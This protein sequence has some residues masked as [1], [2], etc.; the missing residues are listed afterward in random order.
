M[1][2]KQLP[3]PAAAPAAAPADAV[4]EAR[5]VQTALRPSVSAARAIKALGTC[6]SA[7]L[8][9]LAAELSE[10]CRMVSA[11][12]MDRPEAILVAQAATLD[13]AFT[14][15]LSRAAANFG[16]HLDAAQLYMRLALRAQAQ[17]ARTLET[18]GQL[19]NPPASA[20]FIKQANVGNAVQV[21]NGGDP[22]R[23]RESD[24]GR[25]ELLEHTDGDRL[26]TRAAGT[27]SCADPRLEAVETRHRPK[28][29]GR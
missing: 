21:N 5:R 7:D 1:S 17:C 2:R 22:A 20:T 6:G 26:D 29:R 9:A 19:R 8:A 10:Q 15:L 23:A 27:A 24:F 16:E 14:L 3:A 4:R 18:L 28:Q 25:P 13:Q 11:G 12:N